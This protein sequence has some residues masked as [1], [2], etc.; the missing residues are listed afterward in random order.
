[1]CQMVA[2]LF[3]TLVCTGCVYLHHTHRHL[4]SLPAKFGELEVDGSLWLNNNQPETSREGFENISV[5]G[6]LSLYNNQLTQQA[7]TFPNVQGAREVQFE[8][9]N[10]Y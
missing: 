3:S 5:G 4:E 9:P 7:C 10:D 2:V 1:M 8:V 6:N